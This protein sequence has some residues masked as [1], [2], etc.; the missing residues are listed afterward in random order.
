MPR[1]NTPLSSPVTG[2]LRCPCSLKNATRHPALPARSPGPAPVLSSPE[3]LQPPFQ[4]S[5]CLN[6]DS[7]SASLNAAA[8]SVQSMEP[9]PSTW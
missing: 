2:T 1:E 5:P 7:C 9:L 8:N 6:G 4:K 3:W